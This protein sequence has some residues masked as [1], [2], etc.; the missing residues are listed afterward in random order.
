MIRA[1]QVGR[2]RGTLGSHRSGPIFY[3]R[4][5]TSKCA[6][7]SSGCTIDIDDRPGSVFCSSTGTAPQIEIWGCQLA[8]QCLAHHWSPP[9]RVLFGRGL[10]DLGTTS[11]KMNLKLARCSSR[12]RGFLPQVLLALCMARKNTTSAARSVGAWP[13][14]FTSVPMIRL[15]PSS[16]WVVSMVC[17]ISAGSA[18]KGGHLAP[19]PRTVWAIFRKIAVVTSRIASHEALRSFHAT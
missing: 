2:Q 3:F 11:A 18:K 19:K 1:K 13:L 8:H 12:S 9:D 5:E 10:Q 14:V 4:I 7:Q 17:R 6:K 15:N 16:E